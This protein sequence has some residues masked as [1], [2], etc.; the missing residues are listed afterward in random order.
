MMDS[1]IDDFLMVDLLINVLLMID[2]LIDLFMING[3]EI[4]GVECLRS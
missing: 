2:L 3:L 4:C 1:S